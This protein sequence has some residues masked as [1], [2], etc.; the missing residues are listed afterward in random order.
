MTKENPHT[1]LQNVGAN[2]SFELALSQQLIPDTKRITLLNS[3]SPAW[4]PTCIT[5]PPPNN[6]QV[7]SV[8]FYG[9]THFGN[10]DQNMCV[11]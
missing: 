9:Q 4:P 11:T 8:L 6:L 1:Y 7:C 10:R 5:P 2:T 3:S